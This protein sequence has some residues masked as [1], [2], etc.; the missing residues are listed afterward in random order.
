MSATGLSTPRNIAPAISQKPVDQPLA[1]EISCSGTLRR[2]NIQQ[3]KALEVLGHALEYLVDFRMFRV[4]ESTSPADA[5][6]IKILAGLSRAIFAECREVKPLRRR[7]RDWASR[8]AA[9]QATC[10]KVR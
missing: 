8:G 4:E 3:G 1:N 6:A 2:G 10:D 7:L 9:G 5:E